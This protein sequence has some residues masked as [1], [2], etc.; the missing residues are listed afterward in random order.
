MVTPIIN[1]PRRTVVAGIADARTILGTWTPARP[2]RGCRVVTSSGS[3][4]YTALEIAAIAS[5]LS[6]V[7]TTP[8]QGTPLALRSVTRMPIPFQ[9]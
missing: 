5:T 1:V 8:A 6:T 3:E 2:G 9:L 7:T 4:S